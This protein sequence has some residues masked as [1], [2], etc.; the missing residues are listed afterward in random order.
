M[1]LDSPGFMP[2]KGLYREHSVP[3]ALDQVSMREE[4]MIFKDKPMSFKTPQYTSSKVQNVFIFMDI[5]I[6]IYSY[7]NQG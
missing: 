2:Y 4:Y 5:Y 3:S 1:Y 6:Y 7:Q